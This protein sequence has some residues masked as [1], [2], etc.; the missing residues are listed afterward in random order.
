MRFNYTEA[1]PT[2]IIKQ[3]VPTDIPAWSPG[4]GDLRL[5]KKNG[6]EER[7]VSD[8][9]SNGDFVK[10][11]TEYTIQEL[12]PD[13]EGTLTLYVEA[14]RKSLTAADIAVAMQVK[15][16]GQN[17]IE[18]DKVRFT[19]IPRV[20]YGSPNS[21]LTPLPGSKIEPAFEDE[22]V[23]IGEALGGIIGGVGQDTLSIGRYGPHPNAGSDPTKDRQ[24]LVIRLQTGTE[25]FT[26]GE[27]SIVLL[28]AEGLSG[29]FTPPALAAG[30]SGV[31]QFAAAGF[32]QQAPAPANAAI[33]EAD[34][35]EDWE[36][37]FE[38]IL[39]EKYEEATPRIEDLERDGFELWG[40]LYGGRSYEFFSGRE[41]WRSGSK[42]FIEDSLTP[43]QA[44]DAY[45]NFLKQALPTDAQ[46]VNLTPILRYYGEI[47]EAAGED[48]AKVGQFMAKHWELVET[49]TG[50]LESEYLF[51]P[52]SF[53]VG[54]VL[55]I[56][57]VNNMT[58]YTEGKVFAIPLVRRNWARG[59]ITE[60]DTLVNSLG[61]S[62]NAGLGA[63][64]VTGSVNGQPKNYVPDSIRPHW[65]IEVKDWKSL[66][67]T[68]QIQ[69][70]F[71]AATSAQKRVAII[72]TTRNRRL[73]Q[74]LLDFVETQ[75]GLLL[76]R[77]LNTDAYEVWRWDTTKLW[78]PIDKATVIQWLSTP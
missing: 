29:G 17:W 47:Y 40:W 62:R 20:L 46:G 61:F 22:T 24:R 51:T 41:V 2:G 68:S 1:N 64:K 37:Q 25:S 56:R 9:K 71:S 14:L 13:P 69:A 76:R 36:A 21:S 72:I 63:I 11:N 6:N 75:G 7:K 77:N 35:P 38:R 33:P 49:T 78:E 5:W 23:A 52:L 8:V 44:A 45:Y 70:A 26:K 53:A 42:I 43:E 19:A 39:F 59:N 65:Y 54:G 57:R 16:D 48:R 50:M 4:A 10:A 55:Q 15:L 60:N 30:A 67:K 27:D 58:F 28:V 34:A 31:T 3:N 66:S 18:A 73:S 74:P 12:G 32:P